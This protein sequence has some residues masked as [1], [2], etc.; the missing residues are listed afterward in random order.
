MTLEFQAQNI[1]S[2]NWLQYNSL[3][4]CSENFTIHL[5]TLTE[6]ESPIFS[7]ISSLVVII[8]I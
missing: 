1:N 8:K 2:P 6:L 4:C 7:L 3:P 5:G